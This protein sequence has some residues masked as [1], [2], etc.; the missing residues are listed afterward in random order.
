MKGNGATTPSDDEAKAIAREFYKKLEKKEAAK[1]LAS[2]H[3]PTSDSATPDTQSASPQRRRSPHKPTTPP[4]K[5]KSSQAATDNAAAKLRA[6][7]YYDNFV[8]KMQSKQGQPKTNVTLSST[9]YTSG[10]P[11]PTT[12]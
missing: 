7:Q 9:K 12:T 2:I 3:S 6:R 4:N 11:T 5:T 10:V 1:R 8:K